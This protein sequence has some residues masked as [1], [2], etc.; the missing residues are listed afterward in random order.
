VHKGWNTTENNPSEIDTPTIT[1]NPFGVTLVGGAEATIGRFNISYDFKPAINIS[2]GEKSFYTQSG[3]S[4]RYVLVKNK[5]WRKM[6]KNKK[7][8]QKAKAKA[9]RGEPKWKFWKN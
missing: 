4:L 8:K 7:K 6:K 3:V 2:G 5:V 9:K 1:A